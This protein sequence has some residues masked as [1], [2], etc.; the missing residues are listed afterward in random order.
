MF[1]NIFGRLVSRKSATLKEEI[2]SKE[3]RVDTAI[4]CVSTKRGLKYSAIVYA[5]KGK[6]RQAVY[7]K[8][9][10][11]ALINVSAGITRY[12]A[13]I[14]CWREAIRISR[15]LQDKGLNVVLDNEPFSEEETRRLLRTNENLPIER[16]WYNSLTAVLNDTGFCTMTKGMLAGKMQRE[17]EEKKE[18]YDTRMSQITSSLTT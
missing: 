9:F 10:P 6:K 11:E 17:Y 13:E 2:E 1:K 7:E 8:E 15:E 3:V 4:S 5:T 16:K 14:M 12:S 18:E